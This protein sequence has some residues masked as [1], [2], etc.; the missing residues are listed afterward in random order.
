MRDPSQDIDYKMD[1][2]PEKEKAQPA[3]TP[4]NRK[5]QIMRHLKRLE[6]QHDNGEINDQAFNKRKTQLL[7]KLNK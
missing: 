5:Q 6:D 2:I 1:R 4:D 3:D 7:A